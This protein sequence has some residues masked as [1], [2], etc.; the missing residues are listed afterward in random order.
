MWSLYTFSVQENNF[1]FPLCLFESWEKEVGTGREIQG[2]EI[3]WKAGEV[4]QTKRQENDWQRKKENA[5]QKR[6]RT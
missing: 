6:N 3:V 4:Y 1:E 2:I 5:L